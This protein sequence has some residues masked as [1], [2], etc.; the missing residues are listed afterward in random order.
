MTETERLEA[1]VINKWAISRHIDGKSWEVHEATHI[2]IGE[3]VTFRKAIDDAI[4]NLRADA[5]CDRPK[6]EDR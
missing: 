3:G 4:M 1:V 6:G 2:R 5:E